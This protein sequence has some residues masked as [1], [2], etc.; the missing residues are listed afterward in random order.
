MS[1]LTNAQPDGTP[2]WIDLR[3]AEYDRT[4][5][6]YGALF[7]WEYA[8]EPTSAGGRRN[9]TCLLHGKP[10][11]AITQAPATTGFGW[12]MYIATADCDGT[13]KRIAD[14]GGTLL[15]EPVDVMAGGTLLE[16]PVD[17]M[18]GGARVAV[19]EDSVGARF[20]LWQARTRIGCEIVNEPGS[21]VRNDLL[22]PTPG[23]ARAFYSAVFGYTLDL[24]DVMPEADFTFLRRPDGHE[25]GGI[26]GIPKPSTPTPASTPTSAWATTFEVADTDAVAQQ[27]TASGGTSTTPEDIP[28][29]RI[30]TIT[31]PN[32]NEF[33]VITRP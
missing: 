29:G 30:A 9:A 18:A 5:E 25:I 16:E 12:T 31:D 20:G 33:S 8:E 2:T 32:G 19:A 22:T 14:A 15:E 10:V 3:V 13:A 1:H 21:L 26:F 23:P 11:A 17:D 6:F 24:N 7:G 27:A 4:L 28:Y